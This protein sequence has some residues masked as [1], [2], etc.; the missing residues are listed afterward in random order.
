MLEEKGIA[1]KSTTMQ[2]HCEIIQEDILIAEGK[3]TVEHFK[4]TLS[5]ISKRFPL[6]FVD[7]VVLWSMV[8][9]N[10]RPDLSS[11]TSKLQV[12]FSLGDKD[13]FYNAY[14]KVNGGYPQLYLLE[15]LL[16]DFNSSYSMMELTSIYDRYFT[17]Q[18][19]VTKE[20]EEFL[21]LH[22][23]AIKKNQILSDY[24]I[25]GDESLREGESLPKISF[26]S[27]YKL[28]RKFPKK[29]YE[30]TNF[31]FKTQTKSNLTAECN[32]EMS[33]YENSIFL[34]NDQLLKSHLFG[35]KNKNNMF[36]A[37]AS[38]SDIKIE[39]IG[40]IPF[41]K[42]NSNS[43]SAAMCRFNNKQ[44]KTQMWFIS[45]QSRDPGQH[46]FH[47]MEYGLESIDEIKSLDT[48]IKFSR[49]QF[50]KN[51]VRLVIESRRS[52]DKQIDEL[53]KLNIPIYNSKK[54][55]KI[56]AY[57]KSKNQNSFLLD[58]R[59]EGHVECSSN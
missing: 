10:A 5:S 35:L 20:F 4:K 48:M 3:N 7:R 39:P 41:F 26:R 11:P 56:W 32:F 23:L 37:S 50:L 42:G 21:K 12:F 58:D 59:R 15:T 8:Q 36:F 17:S 34:I 9:M 1:T 19:T 28:Y 49:H 38:Q 14:S 29:N 53:L 31:L 27:L 51:P 44:N 45:S 52:S 22:Q 18:L 33:L 24:Y 2:T 16:K 46:I 30:V 43:R 54:L 55:G 57:Y 40:K 25:R 13:Y 6:K 47:L